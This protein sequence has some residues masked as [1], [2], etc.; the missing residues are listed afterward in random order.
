MAKEIIFIG[1]GDYRKEENVGVDKYI[2]RQLD[3]NSKIIIFPFAVKKKEKRMS[4]FES[5]KK[6]FLKKGIKKIEMVEEDFFLKKNAKDI[7]FSSDAIFL[8][9]GDPKLLLETIIKL[10]IQNLLKN[11]RGV[12]IGYSAGAMIFGSKC[13][14][15]GGIEEDY[16]KTVILNDGIRLMDDL[17]ISPHYKKE[18][19]PILRDL[20]NK[21][22]ICGIADKS[23]LIYKNEKFSKIGCVVIFKEGKKYSF[24]S[25]FLKQQ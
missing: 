22:L 24:N 20:S 5:I 9:G 1:G 4:R 8:T 12:I 11:F 6:V 21:H 25:S 15:P 3:K 7:I 18:N 13:V 10:N 14:I 2:A 17:V 23:A 16:P 19:D